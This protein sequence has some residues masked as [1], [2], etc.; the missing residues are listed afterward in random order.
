MHLVACSRLT[1]T[2]TTSTLYEQCVACLVLALTL[3]LNTGAHGSFLA[4]LLQGAP[5][6]IGVIV[7]QP[8]VLP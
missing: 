8:Q 3:C 5:S 1:C 4:A 6:L 2:S 7:D